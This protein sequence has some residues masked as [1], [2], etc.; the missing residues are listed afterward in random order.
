MFKPT[1]FPAFWSV[2]ELVSHGDDVIYELACKTTGTIT[3]C[4]AL[5]G[6]CLLAMEETKLYEKFSMS[7]A[8]H[9]AIGALGRSQ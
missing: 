5:V 6:R 8:I 3:S 1:I 7:G 2:D 4:K 9:F